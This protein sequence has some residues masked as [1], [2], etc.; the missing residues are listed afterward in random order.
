MPG[1]S[2]ECCA[3]GA[4]LAACPCWEGGA[5]AAH[6]QQG[7]LA[8]NWP[9]FFTLHS[10]CFACFASSLDPTRLQRLPRREAAQLARALSGL[11][12]GLPALLAA[13]ASEA[14]AARAQL[15]PSAA[16][17]ASA[18][19]VAANEFAAEQEGDAALSAELLLAGGCKA[20]GD[21]P[22]W[23]PAA[24]AVLCCSPRAM[25][26][27]PPPRRPS[28]S[29]YAP[30]PPPTH[31]HTAPPHSPACSVDR[32][33]LHQPGRRAGAA[34]GRPALAAALCWAAPR[35]VGRPVRSAGKRRA[36]VRLRAHAEPAA[37]ACGWRRRPDCGRAAGGVMPA[38]LLACQAG[39]Q[40]GQ[41]V[42]EASCC[43][44]PPT[45]S[46]TISRPCVL[47]CLTCPDLHCA[48]SMPSAFKPD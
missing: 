29:P 4:G 5:Q 12:G 1:R 27:S 48:E 43:C 40:P 17:I 32:G 42:C 2:G 8:F 36:P 31:E 26:L 7:R 35:G 20:P 14:P 6:P 23:N 38:R 11:H 47:T 30:S 24:P 41:L 15:V 16:A 33:G 45:H 10:A 19:F 18:L 13:T 37:F 39:G 46:S 25:W 9:L 28:F 34:A 44:P 3:L 22:L 21:G